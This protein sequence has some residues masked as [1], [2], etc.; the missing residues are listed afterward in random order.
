MLDQIQLICQ[1]NG[2]LKHW[3]K[4]IVMLIPERQM[5]NFNQSEHARLS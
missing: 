3:Y 2:L 5:G 1:Q 4:T